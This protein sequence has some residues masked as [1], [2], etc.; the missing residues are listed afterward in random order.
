MPLDLDLSKVN[1]ISQTDTL[2]VNSTPTFIKSTTFS[3]DATFSSNI[4]GNT[5]KGVGANTVNYTTPLTVGGSTLA[6]KR[7]LIINGACKMST[8]S[9]KAICGNPFTSSTIP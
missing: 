9:F 7:N 8:S 3:S 4:I 6:G 1:A 2:S 5:I